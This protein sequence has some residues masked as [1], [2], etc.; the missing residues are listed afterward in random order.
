MTE[1][2][3]DLLFKAAWLQGDEALVAWQKWRTRVNLDDYL[4][5]GSYRLLPQLYRNLQRLGVRDPLMRKLKGVGRLHWSRNQLV[6]Q[7]LEEVHDLLSQAGV[8]TIVLGEIAM[9][10][11]VRADYALDP[12][13]YYPLLVRADQAQKA[14]RRLR[15][16]G[17][18]PVKG[19]RMPDGGRDLSGHSGY[20]LHDTHGSRVE[21]IG[22]LF[23]D[24]PA[25]GE[26]EVAV[27]GRA[28]K[29]IWG[30]GSLFTLSAEDQLLYIGLQNVASIRSALFLQA[31]DAALVMR[32]FMG[33]LD[34]ERL[35]RLAERR[36]LL[37]PLQRILGYVQDMLGKD[38]L[39]TGLGRILE[40]PASP[41]ERLRY[42]LNLYRMTSWEHFPSSWWVY[43]RQNSS[44][45]RLEKVFGFVKLLSRAHRW[46]NLWQVP[47]LGMAWLARK[48]IGG[49]I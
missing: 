37:A 49:S 41:G 35:S 36:G 31:I 13:Y 21:L 34:G 2:L 18:L 16:S 46:R 7:R 4:D 10:L 19:R 23:N 8:E 30:K 24:E 43:F 45:P 29:Q 38:W 28:V 11:A 5:P 47:A 25:G 33:Q 9:V 27:W 44:A 48:V 40:A 26:E 17:W 32:V 42:R 1:P 3:Q 39:P 12:P 22:G 6:L 20:L 15:E 14:F